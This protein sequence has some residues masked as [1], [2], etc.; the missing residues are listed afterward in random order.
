MSP[1][2]SVPSKISSLAEPAVLETGSMN[3]PS[4]PLGIIEKRVAS[5]FLS[6]FP[7]K[8]TLHF[9]TPYIALV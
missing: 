3:S 8:Y 5:Y 4:G 9:W 7:D 6:W 1:G 2:R